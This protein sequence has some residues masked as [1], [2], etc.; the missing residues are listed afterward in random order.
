MTG[1]T[2]AGEMVTVQIVPDGS[3]AANPAFDVTPARLV[4]AL[5]TE[6]G[7]CA[8]SEAG[9]LSLYPEQVKCRVTLTPTARV[10]CGL[11]FT[12]IVGWGTVYLMPSV[13]GRHIQDDLSISSE[14]VFAGITVMFGGGRPLLAQHR[15]DRRPHR[16]APSDD[17]GIRRLCA[18]DRGTCDEPGT[19]ELARLLGGARHRLG[20]RAQHTVQHR[21]GAGGGPRCAARD[22]HADHHRRPRLVGL[23]AAHR[24]ARCGHGLAPD[25][26]GLCRDP[27]AGL[28]ADPFLRAAAPPAG[29]STQPRRDGRHGR[30]GAGPALA[31]LP[32]AV[33]QPLLRR[34]RLHRRAGPHDR[35]PARPGDTRR[36]RRCCSPR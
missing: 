31:H 6:R 7:V 4:T 27:P 24:R 36:P 28:R 35:D 3:P 30:D 15:Q 26:A 17:G 13:L 14:V 34:L 21:H 8:A 5:V 23:L 12:Q 18:G 9:L 25:A 32:A 2:E 10:T 11:G 19:G 33:D 16:C 20:P 22:L 29:A 1:R